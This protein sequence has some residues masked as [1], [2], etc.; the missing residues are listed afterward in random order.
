MVSATSMVLFNQVGQKRPTD[1]E[2]FEQKSVGCKG[3]SHAENVGD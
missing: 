1:K 2:Q 3:A